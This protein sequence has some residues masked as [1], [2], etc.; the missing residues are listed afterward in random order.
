MK[1]TLGRELKVGDFVF[2]G[3]TTRY[4]EF[5]ICQISRLTA[6]QAIGIRLKSDRWHGNYAMEEGRPEMKIKESGHC[7]IIPDPTE[8]LNNK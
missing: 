5:A 8:Y 7:I 1:D 2:Y 6:K 4:A 3:T